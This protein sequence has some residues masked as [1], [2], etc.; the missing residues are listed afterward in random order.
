MVF[1]DP[2]ET[3]KA[4]YV[5]GED[6]RATVCHFMQ[7]LVSVLVIDI[8]EFTVLSQNLE[9]GMLCQVNYRAG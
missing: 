6:D 9:E 5:P 2:Q 7:C 8:R 4:G 3:S 1:H